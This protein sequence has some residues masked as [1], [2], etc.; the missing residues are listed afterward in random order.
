MTY[1]RGGIECIVDVAVVGVVIPEGMLDQVLFM[2]RCM[3]RTH[4]QV[5]PFSPVDLGLGKVVRLLD[6]IE[7]LS[8]G[9]SGGVPQHSAVERERCQETDDGRTHL[10]V[11]QRAQI[12][13]SFVRLPFHF[14][15]RLLPVLPQSIGPVV[16]SP[17]GLARPDADSAEAAKQQRSFHTASLLVSF[18]SSTS[19]NVC[20]ICFSDDP[21]SIAGF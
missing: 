1:F 17:N 7:F 18:G 11:A 15:E 9:V 5:V 6:Y 8:A 3:H 12:V 19:S 14:I 10:S 13:E 21:S 2:L 16:I 20:S 4:Q